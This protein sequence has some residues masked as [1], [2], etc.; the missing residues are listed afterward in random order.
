MNMHVDVSPFCNVICQRGFVHRLTV[1]WRLKVVSSRSDLWLLMRN[2]SFILM[3]HLYGLFSS[4]FLFRC[5]CSH[6]SNTR[7]QKINNTPPP[8][9]PII[10]RSESDGSVNLWYTINNIWYDIIL[11]DTSTCSVSV[12]QCHVS[13]GCFCCRSLWLSSIWLVSLLPDTCQHWLA[14]A[15]EGSSAVN[16][17]HGLVH[18]SK[19][20]SVTCQGLQSESSVVL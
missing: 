4:R 6:R 17:V 20:G 16:Q 15:T 1:P 19:V 5:V 11:I 18:R 7:I 14:S 3:K 8:P 10:N 2:T 13:W 9:P 12:K